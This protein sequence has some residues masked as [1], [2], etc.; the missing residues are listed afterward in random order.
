MPTPAEVRRQTALD[1]IVSPWTLG[2]AVLGATALLG[3]WAVG[4]DPAVLF[5]GV[6]GLMAG[7]GALATRWVA[8]L[9]AITARAYE[10]LTAAER[11]DRE[12]D[13]DDLDRALQ[14]DGQPVSQKL[15]RSLRTIR[16]GLARDEADGKLGGAGGLLRDR[17]EEVF[18]A[19]VAQLRRNLELDETIR[20]LPRS[21]RDAVRQ[22]RRALLAEV[23]E[24]VRHLATA[25]AEARAAPAKRREGDLSN[26]RAELDATMEV[27]RRTE[28]RLNELD[29]DAGRVRE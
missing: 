12:R 27:A 8:G 7:A 19:C 29:A 23:A 5:A 3:G 9:E 14:R 2:P 17:A 10:K 25:A 11:A 18:A 28:R 20:A 4:A 16:D 26:L 13:L 21:A 24:T 6:G 1:L 22:E 15:L